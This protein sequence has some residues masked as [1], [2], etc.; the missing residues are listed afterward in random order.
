[1]PFNAIPSTADGKF[2]PADVPAPNTLDAVAAIALMDDS[3]ELYQEIAQAYLQEIADL[4]QRLNGLLAQANLSE[5]ARTL[6]TFKGLS[7]TVGANLLS[8]VCRKCELHLKSLQQQG[9]ALDDAT[10]AAMKEALDLTITQTDA[11]LLAVLADVNPVG[12]PGLE[13]STGDTQALLADLRGLRGML[14]LSDMRALDLQASLWERYPT[15]QA[16]LQSLHQA[17]KIF[18]FSQAV[19]QCDELI[20]TF[21]NTSR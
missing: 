14:I 4:G 19:F 18:N 7:L 13:A 12:T 2:L 16:S 21:S 8:E 10:R 15:R 3:T 6:H 1:M 9:R 11:A 17:V 20:R 5:A